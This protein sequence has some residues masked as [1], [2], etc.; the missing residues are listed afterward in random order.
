MIEDDLVRR[1][2]A[3]EQA[4]FR[5]L[6]DSYS[7][8]TE[9]TARV[10][11]A[12]RRDAEDAVQDAWLDAWRGLHTFQHGRPFRPWILT[13]VSNR[14]RMLARKAKPPTAP[15]DPDGLSHHTTLADAV[16]PFGRQG[17][18]DY[19]ALQTALDGLDSEH[20]KLL[21]LRFFA[22]L[23]LDEIAALLNL[24]AGTVK[25]RLHRTLRTLRDQLSSTMAENH[26]G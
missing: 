13:L 15:L 17:G 21:A 18:A 12:D 9:R 16:Y 22:D 11:L 4:A 8:L 25:S 23:Q 14:C 10:L 19:S 3:G 2:Q 6:L 1:A 5:Q 26:K 20:K 24:P 7:T